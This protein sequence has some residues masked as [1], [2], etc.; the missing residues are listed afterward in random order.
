M[1]NAFFLIGWQVIFLFLS[2]LGGVAMVVVC[3]EYSFF[4]ACL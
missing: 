1:L 2:F 3:V 4:V